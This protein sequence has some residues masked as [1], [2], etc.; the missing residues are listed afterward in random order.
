MSMLLITHNLGIVGDIADTVMVMYAGEVMEYAPVAS[1]FDHPMHP[2][3]INL[4]ET[5]P[6]ID[7]RKNR[8]TVI[9]GEVPSLGNFPAG[10]PFHPRCNRAQKRCTTSHPE[11]LSPASGHFV[12]CLLYE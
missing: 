8:L 7:K 5:I 6:S 11:L 3:T 9:P 2:Y 1:L 4:L 12:R 10:C